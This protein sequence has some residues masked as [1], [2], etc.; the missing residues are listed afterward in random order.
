LKIT[1]G[2]GTEQRDRNGSGAFG[3]KKKELVSDGEGDCW[4]RERQKIEVADKTKNWQV[5][6]TTYDTSHLDK[7]TWRVKIGKQGENVP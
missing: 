2:M 7:K 1:R 3:R 6:M 5:V 4:T